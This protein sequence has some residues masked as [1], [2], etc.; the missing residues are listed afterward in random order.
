MINQHKEETRDTMED[1]AGLDKAY[2]LESGSF[3]PEGDTLC[4]AGTKNLRSVWD[5]LK[6][7]FGLTSWADRY[8]KAD[9]VLDAW[10]QATRIVGHSLGDAVALELPK[11]TRRGS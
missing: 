2:G 1:R 10:P 9:K 7:P 4:V 8:Q 11:T 5:D 3:V 6:S